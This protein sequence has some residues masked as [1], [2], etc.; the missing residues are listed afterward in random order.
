MNGKTE[1]LVLDFSHTYPKDIEKHVG[2]LKRIDLSDIKETAMY[3]S[4]EAKQEIKKTF[5]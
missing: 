1:N 2:N 3:C 5:M 4:L